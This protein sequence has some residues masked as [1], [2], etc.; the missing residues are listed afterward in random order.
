MVASDYARC[1]KCGQTLGMT[2]DPKTQDCKVDRC[3]D[4]DCPSNIITPQDDT[5]AGGQC[6]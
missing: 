3:T 1:P 6:P 2:I 4:P 5:P